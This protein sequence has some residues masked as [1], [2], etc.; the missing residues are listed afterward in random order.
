MERDDIAIDNPA[1][2]LF[3]KAGFTEEYRTDEI[4]MLKKELKQ[5]PRRIIVI[6]SPGSGKSTFA[7]KLRDKTGL[8]LYYLDMIYHNPD[9]TTVSREE[10]E[11]RLSDI[12]ET[13]EWVIDGNYQ[14]SFWMKAIL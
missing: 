3:L 9:R 11:L 8:P 13:D 14:R 7:R 12:L 1:A 2:R 4:I 10:F 6:G 5:S